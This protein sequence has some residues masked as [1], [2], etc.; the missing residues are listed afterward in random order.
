MISALVLAAGSSSRM[1]TPKPL[2]DIGGRPM[3]GRVLDAVRGSRVG[4]TIVVLGADADRVRALP[5]LAGL[6]VVENPAHAEGM[7]TSLKAGTA[8]LGPGSTAFLVVLGD[9]PFLRSATIDALVA[10]RERSGARIV[11]PVYAGIRGNPVLIDRSLAPEVDRISGDRGC[12]ALRLHHPEESVEVPVDDPGVLIDLDTPEDVRRAEELLAAGG[13]L[14]ALAER[15]VRAD[16]PLAPSTAAP[17][18][19]SR[20]R[21]D[22]LGRAAELERRREPFCLAIVTHVRAPTSGKPGFKAI[23]RA[24]GALEGWVGGSCS[25]RALLVESRAALEDGAPRVL[26]LRPV[27]EAC[28]A[29]EPGTVDR[30]LECDSGGA[31]EIYVEP[32]GPVP[33]LVVVGDSP[34]AESLTALG[35][36][37]GFRP[38]AAGTGLDPARFPDADEVVDDLSQL[39]GKLDTV[40]YGIVATMANYDA[41]AL[42][43]LLRSPAPYVA[44]VAS[45]RRAA[46]L[47]E[48]LRGRGL[49]DDLLRRVHSPAGIDIAARTPEEIALSIAAE[50]VR[51]R[52]RIP[53]RAGVSPAP[54]EASVPATLAVDPV[55]HMEVEP[56]TTPLRATHAGVTYYFCSES[57]LRR[58]EA[59]PASFLA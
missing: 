53:P 19:R 59:D 10:A 29:P 11:L 26:R 34:L 42:E 9:A 4:E 28:P 15:D 38:V 3:L 8:A 39:A 5:D 13:S 48:E 20:G 27:T 36:L 18:A 6:R 58:F 2:V 25:R 51:E 55:C 22:L 56:E 24:D 12:R 14:A 16:H 1:G 21:P 52:N 30:V 44:L 46:L 49:S 41:M 7:S 43:I 33:Q 40:S 32:H 37:L 35:R 54:A 31:M 50:V 45:R 23:V 47:F 57:C 17:R